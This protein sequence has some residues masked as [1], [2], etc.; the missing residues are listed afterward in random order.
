MRSQTQTL[1]ILKDA[2][3]ICNP[4]L[5]KSVTDAYLYGS[6]AR[7]DSRYDSDVDFACR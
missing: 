5:G 6:Y 2:Y 7:G 1:E 4:L 3:M